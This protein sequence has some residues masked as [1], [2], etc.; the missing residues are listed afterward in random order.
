MLSL[1]RHHTKPWQMLSVGLHTR[2]CRNVVLDQC[3]DGSRLGA[4]R[5]HKVQTAFAI[6]NTAFHARQLTYITNAY[7][8]DERAT[9]TGSCTCPM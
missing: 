9:S 8:T 6:R 3:R 1:L 5:D 4:R 7:S 2:P